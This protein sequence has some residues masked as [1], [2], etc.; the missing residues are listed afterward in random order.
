MPLYQGLELCVCERFTF[1]GTGT[2]VPGMS[3]Q[4]HSVVCTVVKH[5]ITSCVTIYQRRYPDSRFQVPTLSIFLLYIR[6][7]VASV[8]GWPF[9]CTDA[10]HFP[11]PAWFQGL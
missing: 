8:P 11:V 4:P 2:S 7:D 5:G 6:F 10:L 9:P 1:D 3:A